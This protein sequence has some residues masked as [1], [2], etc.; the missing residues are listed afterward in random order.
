MQ[1]AI[2][3][4]EDIAIARALIAH[5]QAGSSGL[6]Y[7][8]E[9][10]GGD[11]ESPS[12]SSTNLDAPEHEVASVAA[13]PRDTKMEQI[14]GEFVRKKDT[15]EVLVPATWT[16]VRRKSKREKRRSTVRLLACLVCCQAIIYV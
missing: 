7:P 1:R 9:V 8:P 15:E 16:V 3:Y 11:S 4:D 14:P 10:A 13:G 2:H 6:S 5:L 12:T